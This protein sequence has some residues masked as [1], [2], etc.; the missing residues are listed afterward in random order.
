MKEKTINNE[1]EPDRDGVVFAIID[2]G[3]ILLEERID[4]NAPFSGYTIVPGGGIEEGEEPE[5]AV[6]RELDEECGVSPKNLVYLG[7]FGVSILRYV[8]VVEGFR[9]QVVN[10][11]SEKAKHIWA[12]MEEARELCEHAITKEILE[13]V[14][15]HLDST[16]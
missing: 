13:I 9:G 7:V 14:E 1:I 4:I 6:I 11:E 8:F 15:E 5:R 12:T 2:D 10:R 16:R 3:N